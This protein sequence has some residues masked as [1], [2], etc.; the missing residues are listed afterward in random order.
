AF[1]AP[2]K[3]IYAGLGVKHSPLQIAQNIM[4]LPNLNTSVFEIMPFWYLNPKDTPDKNTP[5][6]TSPF[7]TVYNGTNTSSFLTETVQVISSLDSSGGVYVSANRSLFWQPILAPFSANP[8]K[9]NSNT[10]SSGN[11]QGSGQLDPTGAGSTNGLITRTTPLKLRD[12]EYSNNASKVWLLDIHDVTIS[13]VS[14]APPNGT[15]KLDNIKLLFTIDN[16]TY[17]FPPL[18]QSSVSSVAV[19]PDNGDIY[20]GIIGKKTVLCYSNPLYTNETYAK[21][22]GI[23]QTTF[24]S[25]LSLEVDNSGL[26]LYIGGSEGNVDSVDLSKIGSNTSN[27]LSRQRTICFWKFIFYV[28]VVYAIF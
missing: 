20:V 18:N 19:N 15:L 17:P 11:I 8:P 9:S 10:N 24:N 16:T 5:F 2:D 23:I 21:L 25:P 12:M 3:S 26:N 1:E 14:Q 27:A 6:R 22:S 7:P 4:I 28:L 13:S